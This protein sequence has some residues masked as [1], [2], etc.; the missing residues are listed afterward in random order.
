[1]NNIE[2]DDQ[3]VLN[4]F[5]DLTGKD[6]KKAMKQAL[7]KAGNILVRQTRTNLKGIVKNS[8]RKSSKYGTSLASGV[9]V[10][11]VSEREAKVHI[12]GDFRLKFF[13]KGTRMR[14]TKGHRITGYTGRNRLQRSGRG[15]NRGR[16]EG[17]W[18]FKRAQQQS[19]QQV[20]SSIDSLLTQ[21]I[22]RIAAKHK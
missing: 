3:K 22:Q 2:V 1:M 12:M 7:R 9:K 4:L 8:T 19:E 20:F 14:Q 18:F 10:K 6:Q 17:K 15:G 21:S 16:I 13:E 5:A 11:V